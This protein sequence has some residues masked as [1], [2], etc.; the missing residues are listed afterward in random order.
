M[1][2]EQI[3]ESPRKSLVAKIAEACDAVGGIE[4]KG[5]NQKQNYKYMRATDIAKAMRHEFFQRGVI[6]VWDDKDFVQIR[7][8]KTNSGGEM[9]EFLLKCEITFLDAD[10]DAK[11]GPLGAFGV[12]MDTGDKSIWKARTGA[13]KYALR[14]IGM[15]PDEKDDPEADGKVDEETGP[16]RVV[17]AENQFLER[18]GK[19][20]ASVVMVDAFQKLW[21]D[22]GKTDQQLIDVLRTRYSASRPDQL[23]KEELDELVRLAIGKEPLEE[24]LKS[25][26]AATKTAVYE[27]LPPDPPKTTQN[28]SNRSQGLVG[29]VGVTEKQ[30]V[31]L[32]AIAKSHSVS[33]DDVHQF[34]KE[35]CGAESV[36]DLDRASYDETCKFLEAQ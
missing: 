26:V 35:Y 10:S 4:K 30:I 21:H 1:P 22:R 29:R 8:I 33:Q 11:I 32:W 28:P 6:M 31:R 16:S 27:P 3:P 19:Q 20:R 7:T 12:G 14:S 36:K 15:I 23:T 24:T 2:D 13:M 9:G 25:S 18:E 34:I 17:E 5:T